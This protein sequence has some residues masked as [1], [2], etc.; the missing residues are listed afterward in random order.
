ME[1]RFIRTTKTLFDNCDKQL[2]KDSII[3]ITDT[4]QVYQDGVYYP[5]VALKNDGDGEY[6]LAN[7]GTYKNIDELI[8]N[9]ILNSNVVINYPNKTSQLQNDSGFITSQDFH[10]LIQIIYPVG[11]IYIS[12]NNTNPYILFG[13]GEWEQIKDVFLL[14]SG[15]VFSAGQTGGEIE[16]MLTEDEIPTHN[17]T[18]Y[19]HQLWRNETG[20]AVSDLDDG[21]GVSN[22]TLDI[23]QDTT[24]AV[25]GSNPH[26]NMP[27]YLTVYMWKRIS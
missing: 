3:F 24:S 13:F 21:F 5:N 19:R 27:P 17:H 2:Y 9:K 26:N 7:D 15:D 11:S 12:V 22:K 16:H 1:K 4:N 18:F 20:N 25:G 10:Q 8:I 14:A 6:I 23:Y